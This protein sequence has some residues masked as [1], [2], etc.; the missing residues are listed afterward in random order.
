MTSDFN[1]LATAKELKQAGLGDCQA[2]A[3]AD[4]IVKSRN[5][6]A[7]KQDVAHVWR[8]ML[9]VLVPLQLLILGVLLTK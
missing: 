4:S 2:E 6:M 8:V 3:V 5:G 9:G 7:T 1:A